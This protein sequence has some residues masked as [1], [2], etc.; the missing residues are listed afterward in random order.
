MRRKPH[1]CPKPPDGFREAMEERDLRIRFGTPATLRREFYF[2]RATL[3]LRQ[4]AP[5]LPPLQRSEL[6]I[7]G[8]IESARHLIA[9]AENLAEI[10]D[11]H[12][13][14]RLAECYRW[15]FASQDILE[16]RRAESQEGAT[17]TPEAPG[18]VKTAQPAPDASSGQ[19]GTTTGTTPG[20][21][22]A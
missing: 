6:S 2:R 19:A 8:Q 14:F 9:A 1:P 17:G 20:N 7:V 13:S 11:R 18:K 16:E 5:E 3:I 4:H 10:R 21:Q 12:W 22:N 15:L